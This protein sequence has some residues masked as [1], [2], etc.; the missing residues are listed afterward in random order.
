MF[1]S[2]VWEKI[3]FSLFQGFDQMGTDM[4]QLT[5]QCFKNETKLK[6]IVKQNKK[7]ENKT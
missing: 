6:K 3:N 4:K 5:T 7:N 1:S 2:K